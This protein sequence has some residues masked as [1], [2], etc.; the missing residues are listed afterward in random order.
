M[1][2]ANK[3]GGSALE[4]RNPLKSLRR[5]FAAGLRHVSAN[6]LLNHCNHC[7]GSA[8]GLRP[9]YPP[10]Y[11]GVGVGEPPHP[12]P[13]GGLGKFTCRNIFTGVALLTAGLTLTGCVLPI[14]WGALA[15]AK[16]VDVAVDRQQE[17]EREAS[18]CQ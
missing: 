10:P 2:Q 4:V 16:L 5:V 11:R 14:L 6:D 3:C 9:V 13:V 1:H 15:V 18:R 12:H 8:A 7:G 17:C